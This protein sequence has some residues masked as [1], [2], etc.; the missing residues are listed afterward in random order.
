VKCCK[1][2][3]ARSPIKPAA[4]EPAV[5]KSKLPKPLTGQLLQGQVKQVDD[6]NTSICEQLHIVRLIPR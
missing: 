3:A 1:Q 2:H 5:I 4:V 6:I